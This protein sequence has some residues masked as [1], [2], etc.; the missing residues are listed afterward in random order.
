MSKKA[1]SIPGQGPRGDQTETRTC[2]RSGFRW[3]PSRGRNIESQSSYL[4]RQP[5]VRSQDQAYASRDG[6]R[7]PA[8]SQSGSPSAVATSSWG[9]QNKCAVGVAK[10]SGENEVCGAAENGVIRIPRAVR[11]PWRLCKAQA[12]RVVQ[13]GSRTQTPLIGCFSTSLFAWYANAQIV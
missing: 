4:N 10:I 3:S 13:R 7:N 11:C 5:L 9:E 12:Q 6:E 1:G 2:F 8:Q